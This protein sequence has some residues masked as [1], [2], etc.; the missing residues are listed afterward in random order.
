MVSA[1]GSLRTVKLE[2]LVVARLGGELLGVFHGLLEGI[3]LRG[4]RES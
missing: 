2:E 3:A 4:R 1:R